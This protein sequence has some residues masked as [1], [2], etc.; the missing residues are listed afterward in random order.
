MD[1]MRVSVFKLLP[2]GEI[3]VL[4]KSAEK[5]KGISHIQQKKLT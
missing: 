2:S 4:R 1:K 3:V 5:K